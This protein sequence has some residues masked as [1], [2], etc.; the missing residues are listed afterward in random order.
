MSL[1]V[2]T[3]ALSFAAA[4]AEYAAS[5]TSPENAA[6]PAVVELFTSQ[7]CSS[8]P[9][10]EEYLAELA[11]RADV[12]A[13]EWH[14]DYWNDLSVARGGRWQD[15]F[16]APEHTAR[17]RRYNEQIRG[18]PSVYTPQI[19]VNGRYETVGSRRQDVERL[20]AQDAPSQGS[21]AVLQAGDRIAIEAASPSDSQSDVMLIDFIEEHETRVGGGENM[22]TVLREAHI[23]TSTRLIR[24]LAP[25]EIASVQVDSPREGRNCAVILRSPTTGEIYAGRYCAVTSH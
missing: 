9:P 4:P 1:F 5:G 2:V 16:S 18:R 23:A 10:A 11:H 20:V 19:V 24:A 25:G 7:S 22:G 8:C 14:V 3:V 17:Q 12:I 6:R 13:I 15:P 21:I